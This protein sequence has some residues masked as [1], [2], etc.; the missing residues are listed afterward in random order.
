MVS[1]TEFITDGRRNVLP[2]SATLKGDARAL[3]DDT[4]TAIEDAMRR[5]C[6]GIA[7]AQ[8]VG[9]DV[10]YDT[11][12]PAMHNHHEA[13]KAAVLAAQTVAGE[14]KVNPACDPKLFSEDFAHMARAIPGCFMLI[15]NG[16]NASNARPLHAS[17]YD[18]NDEI[19]GPGAAYTATLAQQF[20]AR[21]DVD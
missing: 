4:N 7:A 10:A 20:L 3:S 2:G 6:A 18:F 1:V 9:I 14:G 13:T 21:Q 15:G 8:G 17:D 19:L 12:F 5:I 16:T 11:V